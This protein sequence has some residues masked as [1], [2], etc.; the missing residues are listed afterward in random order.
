MKTNSTHIA[1]KFISLVLAVFMIIGVMPTIAFA[2]TPEYV[3]ISASHDADFIND[4]NGAPLAYRAVALDDLNSIDL[5]TYGLSDYLYDKDGDGNYEITLLHLYIYVHEVI[6]GLDWSDVNVTGSAG[7]I[8]FAGGLFGFEDEN[9]R[10]NYNGAYPA[11][12]NGWG[13]TADRIVLSEGDFIEVAHY[14]DWSF[15]ADSAYGFHYFTDENDEINLSYSAET[16]KAFPVKLIR[17]GGG[18]G[19]SD[20]QTA[21]ARYTVYYG[22]AIGDAIDSVTTDDNGI[23]NITFSDQGTYYI[24]CRGGKGIDMSPD[25]I[26]SSPASATVMVTGEAVIPEQPD[27]PEEKTDIKVTIDEGMDFY[28]SAYCCD[29]CY[30]ELFYSGDEPVTSVNTTI[31]KW[32]CEFHGKNPPAEY[33]V[34][35]IAVS[36][37]NNANY[38]VKG[39]TINGNYYAFGEAEG[40]S[41][42]YTV[43]TYTVK[44]N[45]SQWDTAI[46]ASNYEDGTPEDI[47]IHIH[48][49]KIETETD[50][51]REPQDVSAILNATMAKL[52]STV[53]APAFGTNAG[54]WTVLS[55]ARGGYFA[56]DNAYFTDYYD[57]IVATVNETAASVNLNGALHKNKSTDNSRLIVAL[58]SIGKN[59][60]SVGDWNLVE[61]YSANGFDWIKKQGINGPIWALI[62][63]DSNDYETSDPTIRQQCID[64]ILEKQ[65]EDGGWTLS[66]TVADPDITGMTLQALINYADQEAVAA[67]AAKAIACLSEMQQTSGGFL[68]GTSETSESAAQ[69]IVALTAWGINPDTDSRFVKEDKSVVDAILD[70]YVE[71]EAMFEHQADAG[72]NDMA[73]DQACYALVA[74][75]R[76]VNNQNSLYDMSDV[77]FDAVTPDDGNDNPTDDTVTLDKLT[78]V[79][80]PPAQV[81]G[82]SGTTFDVPVYIVGWNNESGYKLIDMIVSVP[83]GITV[84]EVTAASGL[85]GGELEYSFE[86]ETGKLRV[87]YFDSN[88]NNDLTITSDSFD[89]M[90]EL[91]NIKF[92]V[93]DVKSSAVYIGITGMSVK[94]HSDSAADDSMIVVNTDSANG[95]VAIVYGVSFSAV[96]LYTGDDV[97][98]IPKTKKAVAISVTDITAGD[99]IVYS[100]GTNEIEFK[101]SAEITAKTGIA[102][103]VALVDSSISME[104]F[105]KIENYDIKINEDASTVVFGDSNA[106]GVINAQDALAAVDFWLRKVAAPTDDQIL[107]VNV[108]SDSRINTFDALGIVEH[109][110]NGSEYGVI[111]KAAT[112]NSDNQ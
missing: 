18:M 37:P 8:Y 58:S 54:E 98:L 21:E 53:T 64:F 5:D 32:E 35:N 29:D 25:A 30:T 34:N 97:D 66:G 4:K 72:T 110:V 46:Y 43:G 109:F 106:D 7:S 69:V 82:L 111:T 22:T 28:A 74:Y 9:L 56:K 75:N 42:T 14:T 83:E 55:L 10:Y 31:E 41:E 101:Y 96:C 26:V 63:L 11:D 38:I 105:V 94:F 76:F 88:K 52:A 48:T 3:Y 78:A 112:L 17:V 2:D 20:S 99:K 100:D 67:A 107:A 40:S 102:S 80:N 84:A 51:S 103:Y 27:I 60:T 90:N 79:F 71:D 81:S 87:V 57:R 6:C 65:L 15:Y 89:G 85:T 12:E 108:N 47:T 104:N 93:E 59:A 62:A 61:A 1:T 95:N 45:K 92:K 70:Y 39:A 23:A 24:W 91:F 68:Y 33:K 50:T 16:G 13:F 73:T 36:A 86:K 19:G 49:E 77:A 44:M